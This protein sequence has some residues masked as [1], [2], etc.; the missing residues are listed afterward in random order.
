MF[1]NP[2]AY[3]KLHQELVE[4]F[5]NGTPSLKQLE[6]L[7]YLKQAIKETLR[8]HSAAPGTLP[9]ITQDVGIMIGQH[10]IPAGYCVGAQAHSVHRDVAIWG[11]DAEEWKPE[12]WDNVTKQQEEAFR[13]FSTGKS[14]RG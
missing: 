1:T 6:K 8:L 3:E 7:P 2:Q 11:S 14:I 9:R 5:N 10:H 13:P 4:A 12:R